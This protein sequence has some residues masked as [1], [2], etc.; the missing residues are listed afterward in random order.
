VASNRR[1]FLKTTAL[2]GLGAWAAERG[3]W[4]DDQ[5]GEKVRFACIGVGGKG[6]SDSADAARLG[7]IVAICDIDD[8]TL[9]Q[10]AQKYPD[11]KKYNDYRKM[12]D[13]MGKS[14]DAVTVSTPDHHHAHAAAM[15]MKMGK[16]CFCQKPMTHSLYEARRLGEIAREMKVATQMG[17]EGTAGSG[18]PNTPA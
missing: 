16:A 13:E 18:Q 5:P 15:A 10:A 7:T 2:A 11:A 12:L 17:N 4:A 8:G 6:Q 1:A 9:A 14:I 3:L